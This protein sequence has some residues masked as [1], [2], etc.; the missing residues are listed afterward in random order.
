MG[1]AMLK[2]QRRTVTMATPR[3]GRAPAGIGIGSGGPSAPECVDTGH[4]AE[5]V[6]AG[7]IAAMKSRPS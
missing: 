1:V 2:P 6:R 4:Y 3:G 5:A 7:L